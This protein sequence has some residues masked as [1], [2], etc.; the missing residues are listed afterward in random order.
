ML[1]HEGET[2]LLHLQGLETVVALVTLGLDFSMEKQCE[3][4]LGTG[5]V[6]SPIAIWHVV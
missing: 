1:K 4:A 2:S 5:S 6:H 3:R